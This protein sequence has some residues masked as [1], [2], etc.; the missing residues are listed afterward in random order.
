[1]KL[2]HNN[3]PKVISRPL[4]SDLW[5]LTHLCNIVSNT[6]LNIHQKTV[7]FSKS[8]IFLLN[9]ETFDR[10]AIH[11]HLLKKKPIWGVIHPGSKSM[12]PKVNCCS[13]I[14]EVVLFVTSER[15]FWFNLMY[16]LK[17][18]WCSNY[19]NFKRKY[20]N[21]RFHVNLGLNHE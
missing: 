11:N 1:M 6:S 16:L 21:M 7:R 5:I 12:R 15:G 19:L 9:Y 17:E 20:E 4:S 14:N 2:L 3:F 18:I 8:V 10:K 13:E